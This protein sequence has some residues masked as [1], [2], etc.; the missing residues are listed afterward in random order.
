MLE[1]DALYLDSH[2]HIVLTRNNGYTNFNRRDI[3]VLK[4]FKFEVFF[5]QPLNFYRQKLCKIV[6]A[7]LKN[8]FS[9]IC[10]FRI[11]VSPRV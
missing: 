1:Y 7:Y 9:S 10:G 6:F 11:L 8:L 4:S 2:N 3:F 5:T